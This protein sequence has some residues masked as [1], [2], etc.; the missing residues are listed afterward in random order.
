M[1][2][3]IGDELLDRRQRTLALALLFDGVHRFLNPS[4]IVAMRMWGGWIGTRG[5]PGCWTWC[6]TAW[7]ARA[8][9]M[10]DHS[11]ADVPVRGTV[12]T[13]TGSRSAA[14]QRR[15]GGLN[16]RSEP[17]Q[18]T[19]FVKCHDWSAKWRTGPIF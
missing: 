13:G 14:Q 3:A 7:R 19:I 9:T 1:D 11:C 6:C 10:P 17:L 12:W 2:E 5:W 4:S 8:G 15:Q 18:I 16:G